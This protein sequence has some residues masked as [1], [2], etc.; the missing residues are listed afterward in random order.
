MGLCCL[1]AVLYRSGGQA[2]SLPAPH[3]PREG[4]L[5]L[6]RPCLS[7]GCKA[8]AMPGE[9]RCPEHRRAKARHHNAR[10]N[11][12]RQN[13]PG[14]GAARRRRYRLNLQ[15]A[16]V[17]NECG[18]TFASPALR[19]DHVVPLVDGGLDVAAN[20]QDLCFGCHQDKT[21]EE[22]RRRAGN[23]RSA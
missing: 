20:L 17:C 21:S 9:S 6:R 16:G 3:S 5:P 12:R 2:H 8:L 10:K 22:A 13:A 15:G 18:L 1:A 23:S 11:A 14:D 19:V 7:P 4:P